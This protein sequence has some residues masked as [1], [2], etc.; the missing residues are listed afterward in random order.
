MARLRHVTGAATALLALVLTA[1]S[2]EAQP[3]ASPTTPPA[4][5]SAEPTSEPP[6]PSPSSLLPRGLRDAIYAVGT[7]IQ[8]GTYVTTVPDGRHGC[9]WARL[10]SFGEPDSIIAD[11]NP[12]PGEQVRVTVLPTD[13]GFK[14][15]NGCTWTMSLDL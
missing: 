5:P 14:V 8:P 11:G 15:S 7:D 12:D 2:S 1:C 3:D 6:A 13:R 4:T 9:Y 10:R